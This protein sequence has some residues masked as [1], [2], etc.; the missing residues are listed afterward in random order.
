MSDQT[1]EPKK[2]IAERILSAIGIDP[3][4]EPI[5]ELSPEEKDFQDWAAKLYK[6]YRVPGS[7]TLEVLTSKYGVTKQT[8]AMAGRAI[9]VPEETVNTIRE[10]DQK[11]KK[12]YADMNT[13]LEKSADRRHEELT[14]Q[15]ADDLIAGKP[16]PE[17]YN[18]AEHQAEREGIKAAYRAALTKIS[19][20]IFDLFKPWLIKGAEACEFMIELELRQEIA[21]AYRFGIP[22]TEIGE[23]VL[24]LR[25]A[26]GM[27]LARAA[28]RPNDYSPAST[29]TCNLI[30]GL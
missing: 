18:V 29:T 4:P 17:A 11:Q 2:N 7:I 25:Q 14:G 24:C 21:T 28:E 3:A 30:E 27:L 8:L 16:L 13:E 22:F 26:R 23:H 1:T 5:P 9:E 10:L 12:L 20:Q 15:T 6:P 19:Q